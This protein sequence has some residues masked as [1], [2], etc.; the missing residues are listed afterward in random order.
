[1]E[2]EVGGDINVEFR[3]E[4]FLEGVVCKSWKTTLVDLVGV[5]SGVRRNCG[6]MRGLRGVSGP[7]RIT[8]SS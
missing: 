7:V 4:V 6:L 5:V 8:W 3:V 1:M 2:G